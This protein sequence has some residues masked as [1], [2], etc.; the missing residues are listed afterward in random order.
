VVKK[1]ILE[2]W[3][4][5]RFYN[6]I[7]GIIFAFSISCSSIAV[8]TD[9]DPDAN[10]NNLKS[11]QWFGTK[12]DIINYEVV[13]DPVVEKHVRQAV[14]D[15]MKSKGFQKSTAGVIDFYLTFRSGVKEK[16]DVKERGYSYGEWQGGLYGREVYVEAYREGALV[17]EIIEA[18][19][20]ELIW[21]GWASGVVEDPDQVEKK[22]YQAVKKMLKNF[23]PR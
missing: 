2:D 22:I 6:R 9:F 17:I 5:N 3:Y 11:Y 4:F 20:K 7:I 15:V 8:K 16:I 23:P 14:D 1:L 12:G 21:Q 18:R 19:E 13:S 10:F